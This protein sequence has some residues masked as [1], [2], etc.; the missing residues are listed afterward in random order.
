M[1]NLVSMDVE[2]SPILTIL[3]LVCF[4]I[5]S[6]KTLLLS[7]HRNILSQFCLSVGRQ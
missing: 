4:Y 2:E 3:S 6:D 7:E 1:L 5:L